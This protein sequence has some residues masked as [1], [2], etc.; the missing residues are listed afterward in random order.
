M[1]Q[2]F[3]LSSQT[4]ARGPAALRRTRSMQDFRICISVRKLKLQRI[5]S[6]NAQKGAENDT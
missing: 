1:A 5:L 6:G 4:D 2:I 3:A